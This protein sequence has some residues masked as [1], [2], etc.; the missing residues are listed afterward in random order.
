VGLL[1]QHDT[2]ILVP[3]GCPGRI[4]AH[5]NLVIDVARNGGSS[6]NGQGA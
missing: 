3:P 2:T 6:A 4:D 5:L 1:E